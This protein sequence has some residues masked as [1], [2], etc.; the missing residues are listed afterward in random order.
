MDA[1]VHIRAARWTDKDPAATLI[2]AALH[3]TPLAAWLVPDPA[4][5]RRVLTDVAAIWVEHA[6]FYGD[7]HLTDD[8]S[9]ATVGF[10]RYRPIPPPANY[11][12]RLTDAAGP[13]TDRFDQLDT[14]LSE[15]RP[16]EPH[17]HLAFLAV[18]PDARDA[19]RA[20]AMLTHHRRRLD[21]IDLP[22]WADTTTDAHTLY[23]RHGYTARP[24][25]TLPDGPTL[26]PMRRNP[27][28][29]GAVPI[30]AARPADHR[31]QDLNA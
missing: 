26:Q 23:T 28:R 3:P 11:R 4:L 8:L 7:I 31:R 30:N 13:Y 27:D 5:R 16:T 15:P 6:M 2:A 9:A 19:G 18:H 1:A 29:R 17:Y 21:R 10:H 22:S 12:H 14:L 25:I 20:T 24:A